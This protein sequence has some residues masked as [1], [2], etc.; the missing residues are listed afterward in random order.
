[1][2]RTLLGV[3]VGVGETDSVGVAGVLVGDELRVQA[4]ASSEITKM[5]IPNLLKLMLFMK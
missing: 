2:V 3:W 1:M 5:P 4:A